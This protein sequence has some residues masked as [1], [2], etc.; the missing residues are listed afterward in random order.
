MCVCVCV[1]TLARARVHT[2]LLMQ[3]VPWCA[4]GN[5]KT[6]REIWF[7]PSTVWIRGLDPGCE[8]WQ[9]RPLSTE[10][11]HWPQSFFV[12]F[13]FWDGV[14]ASHESI[15]LLPV[16]SIGLKFI[17]FFFWR[18]SLT[19]P[20]LALYVLCSQGWSQTADPLV[21]TTQVLGIQ[22]CAPSPVERN[23]FC[24]TAVCQGLTKCSG[25]NA[26]FKPH[27]L[28]WGKNTNASWWHCEGSVV[29]NRGRCIRSQ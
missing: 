1:C 19:R 13:V 8:L 15:I 21:S 25:L 7:S 23:L 22:V 9:Q 14:L 29:S 5:Q 12:L 6:T 16:Q 24:V 11:S 26:S 2:C 3:H 28:L 4:Y 10:P 20:R 18:Q 27:E 17:Y